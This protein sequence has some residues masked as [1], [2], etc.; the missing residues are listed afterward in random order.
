MYHSYGPRNV[1]MHKRDTLGMSPFTTVRTL[2]PDD[3]NSASVFTGN[4]LSTFSCSSRCDTTFVQLPQPPP[5]PAPPPPLFAGRAFAERKR[6]CV[7]VLASPPSSCWGRNRGLR[8]LVRTRVNCERRAKSILIHVCRL[9]VLGYATGANELQHL[10]CGVKA[11]PIEKLQ[12][13]STVAVAKVISV[14]WH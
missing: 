2:S 14:M 6:A 12:D 11:R 8:V 4:F 7:V 5:P 1:S 13:S 10:L 3:A 9:V